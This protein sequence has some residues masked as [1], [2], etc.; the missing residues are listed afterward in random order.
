[1]DEVA[2]VDTAGKESEAV[3]VGA[4]AMVEGTEA[5]EATGEAAED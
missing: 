1:M 2:V 5:M 3:E 4:V